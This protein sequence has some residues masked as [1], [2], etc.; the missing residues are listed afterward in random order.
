MAPFR[1]SQVICLARS[2]DASSRTDTI[3]VATSTE[4]VRRR[5]TVRKGIATRS[6]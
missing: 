3:N 5:C 4:P 1:I 2:I 6:S